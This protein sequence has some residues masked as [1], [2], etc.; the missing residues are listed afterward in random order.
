M[1]NISDYIC[2]TVSL[3]TFI[4]CTDGITIDMCL[5]LLLAVVCASCHW[6]GIYQLW[7]VSLWI[8]YNY[9]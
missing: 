5:N 3:Y 8:L 4:K 7:H 6:F 2:A 1:I 9:G